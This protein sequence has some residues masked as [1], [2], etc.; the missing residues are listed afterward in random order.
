MVKVHYYPGDD[1]KTHPINPAKRP[2]PTKLRKTITPG[3]VLI[4]LSGRFKG[5]R[6][7]FL[8]QLASGLLLVTGP[9]KVNGVPLR[10]LNQAYVIATS[11]KVDLTGVDVKSVEDSYFVKSKQRR[12]KSGDFFVRNNELSEEEKNKIQ[13]KKNRQNT[14]DKALL[15]NVKK[16]ECL[17]QYLKTRFS[18]RKNMRPHDMKF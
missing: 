16:V 10:R 11:T 3:T 9:Y 15:A 6:V 17:A 12:T 5:R 14:F 7:V 2:N 1:V 18:L 13:E 8:K 4:V